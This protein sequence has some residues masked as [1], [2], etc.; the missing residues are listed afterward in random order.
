MLGVQVFKRGQL[1]HHLTGQLL[2][3][4]PLALLCALHL[5]PVGCVRCRLVPVYR[6][7]CLRVFLYLQLLRASPSF[8]THGI[9]LLDAHGVYLLDT[10]SIGWLNTHSIGFLHAEST[11]AIVANSVAAQDRSQT[12]LTAGIGSVGHC[13]HPDVVLS[14]WESSTDWS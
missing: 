11:V 9:G 1:G 4:N 10:H 13:C 12:W 7:R 3:Q 6:P 5:G 8:D 14:Y 2:L